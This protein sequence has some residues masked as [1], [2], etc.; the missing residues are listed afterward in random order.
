MDGQGPFRTPVIGHPA[1]TPGDPARSR[2]LRPRHRQ[3]KGCHSPLASTRQTGRRI[4]CGDRSIGTG[5]PLRT[6]QTTP[7]RP[8]G[9]SPPPARKIGLTTRRGGSGSPS[10][11]IRRPHPLQV[12]WSVRKGGPCVKQNR[13]RIGFSTSR[14]GW[15][16][17]QTVYAGFDAS[18]DRSVIV[19]L[20]GQWGQRPRNA[21]SGKMVGATSRR[22][23]RRHD[24]H[25]W[26]RG[27]R[28]ARRGRRGSAGS[29]AGDG[30]SRCPPVS[31]RPGV[32]RRCSRRRGAG[33]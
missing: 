32:R 2:K 18:V 25:R 6:R 28:R 19:S 30:R 26:E 33:G 7:G 8:S 1:R 23:R 17:R 31:W 15:A 27:G 4:T 21:T 20:S 29:G 5:Q 9:S 14:K 24:R 13:A 22:C 11:G 3:G 16:D 12:R 10:Q